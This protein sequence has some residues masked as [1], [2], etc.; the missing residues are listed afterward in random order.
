MDKNPAPGLNRARTAQRQRT[1]V[2]SRPILPRPWSRWAIA[3]SLLLGLLASVPAFA[4]AILEESVPPEGGS[5]PAGRIGIMLRYN[6]RIDKERS[7]LA[8]TGP[9][10]DH[11]TLPIMQAGPPAILTTTTELKPGDYT[12]RW[13][14]LATDGH[15]TRGD[16]HFTVTGP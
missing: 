15:L 1:P 8:L 6:S 4:H 14:V 10:H 11:S 7:K 16:V 2:P 5:V 13:N 12:I 3:A 9:E